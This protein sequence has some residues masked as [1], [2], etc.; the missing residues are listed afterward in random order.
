MK[1]CHSRPEP[2]PP[3]PARNS[4]RLGVES[5]DS[6]VVDLSFPS[7]RP[8]EQSWASPIGIPVAPRPCVA[9]ADAEDLETSRGNPRVGSAPTAGSSTGIQSTSSIF[10]KIPLLQKIPRTIRSRLVDRGYQS[11]SRG[12]PRIRKV[13]G[14]DEAR[15]RHGLVADLA[16][17]RGM[18]RHAVAHLDGQPGR[19]TRRSPVSNDPAQPGDLR[20]EPVGRALAPNVANA[21]ESDSVVT[22]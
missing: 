2:Q 20:R 3:L 15:P 7:S 1:L 10:V 8:S 16:L 21:G 17:R 14:V 5:A 6:V 9:K 12:F 19:H 22:M 18:H 13:R 4:G 11:R